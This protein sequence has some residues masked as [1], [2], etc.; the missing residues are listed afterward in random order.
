MDL[1][2]VGVSEG[3][4]GDVVALGGGGMGCEGSIFPVPVP[5]QHTVFG[6]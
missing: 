3:L 5:V 6:I 4:R 1:V 2:D